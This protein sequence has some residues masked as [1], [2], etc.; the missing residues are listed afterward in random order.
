MGQQFELERI[1]PEKAGIHSGQVKKCIEKL[2]NEWS[3]MNGF[4]A[5]RYGKV[6]AECFW[7][8]FHKDLVHSNHSLGT[9]EKDRTYGIC[10]RNHDTKCFDNDKWAC[11]SS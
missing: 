11:S 1:S 7:S 5:A 8:P 2:M 6:F 10:Q 4:M 9:R 3:H